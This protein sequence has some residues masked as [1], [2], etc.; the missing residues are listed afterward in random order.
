MDRDLLGIAFDGFSRALG[1]L[2]LP[3]LLPI[4]LD[5]DAD[6]DEKIEK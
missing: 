4:L 1:G 3:A 5:A 2:S 6:V